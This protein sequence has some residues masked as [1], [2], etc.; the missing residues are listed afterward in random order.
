MLE[1]TKKSTIFLIILSLMVGVANERYKDTDVYKHMN[2]TDKF[3]NVPQGIELA[4]FGTSHAVHGFYYEDLDMVTFNFSLPAQRIYYDYQILKKY[5]DNFEEGATVIIPISYITFYLGYD[6]ENF[7]EFNKMYYS[8]L[9]PSEI[10]KFKLGDYIKY[11]LLPI[12]TAEENIKYVIVEEEKTER[13]LYNEYT[14]PVE[15][16]IEEGKITAERHLDFIEEGQKNREE[17]V[18]ILDSIVKLCLDNG[19]NPVLTT[20]PTTI[21]YKQ[22][23]P[24]S[25]IDEFYKDINSVVAKYDGVYYLDYSNDERFLN[26]TELYFDSSHLNLSGAKLF[27]KI[28]LED[29]QSTK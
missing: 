28:I 9:K 17:F 18:G 22:H 12:L 10:M 2:N 26:N 4:N 25:F 7:E 5:I 20:I 8:F 14:I 24:Q 13:K 16:M 15:Q 11:K 29:I 1:F 23:F 3:F 19:L 21:Y 6:N 27:T